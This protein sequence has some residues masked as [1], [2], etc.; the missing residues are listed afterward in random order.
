MQSAL[1]RDTLKLA[2][3]AG[4]LVLGAI[5]PVL[6]PALDILALGNGLRETSIT[7]FV[8]EALVT[9]TSATFF[10]VARSKLGHDGVLGREEVVN[11]P[12]R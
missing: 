3:T 5:L 2:S 11:G 8:Q 1:A 7:E 9:L 4:L 6:V 10:L 12:H